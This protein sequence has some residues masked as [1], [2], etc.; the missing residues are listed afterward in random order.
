[1]SRLRL[2]VD[3]GVRIAK[4]VEFL[5]DINIDRTALAARLTKM[6]QADGTLPK[7][8]RVS[9]ASVIRM[10]NKHI[11]NTKYIPYLRRINLR[12]V[13]TYRSPYTKKPVYARPIKSKGGK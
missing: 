7:E 6:M 13:L 12:E 9:V 2:K 5:D 1:M 8:K 4:R 11:V 10:I 3:W